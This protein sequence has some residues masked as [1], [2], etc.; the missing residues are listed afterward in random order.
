MVEKIN[1]NENEVCEQHE[2][3]AELLKIINEKMP[4]IINEIKKEN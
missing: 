2:V 1:V 3:H 4:E